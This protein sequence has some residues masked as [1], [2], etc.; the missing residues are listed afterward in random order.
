MMVKL[1]DVHLSSTPNRQQKSMKMGFPF[2]FGL[3]A[4]VAY[5]I[6]E[7]SINTFFINFMTDDNFMSVMQASEALSLVALLLFMVGRVVG[8]LLMGRT[9]TECIFLT[10]A[11]GAVVMMLIAMNGVGLISKMALIV[12]YVFESIMFPTIFALA[13]RGLGDKTELASSILMMSVVGGAIGPF[14]MGYMGDHYSMNVALVV[15]LSTFVVVLAYAFYCHYHS[16]S[17]QS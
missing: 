16:Y 7:I 2:V 17:P 9:G 4:L 10:C 13:I 1:P 3:L 8:G 12:V 15:P 5:E 6:S 11:V 14:A